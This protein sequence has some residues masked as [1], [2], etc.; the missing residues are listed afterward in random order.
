[1]REL[2]WATALAVNMADVRELDTLGP[3]LLEKMAR[4]ATHVG[5][6]AQVVDSVRLP[7]WAH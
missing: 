5:R 2:R 6:S 1:M 3:S 7:C 4:R